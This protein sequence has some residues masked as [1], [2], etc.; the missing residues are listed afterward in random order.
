MQALKA[1]RKRFKKKRTQQLNDVKYKH[2]QFV[3][4]LNF[5]ILQSHTNFNIQV[6]YSSQPLS[7]VF[8]LRKISPP[9]LRVH[10]KSPTFPELVMA[11]WCAFQF[12]IHLEFILMTGT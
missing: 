3:H 1:F 5:M 8:L 7:F 11:S 6:H 4:F 10:T 9:L 2:S 12:L